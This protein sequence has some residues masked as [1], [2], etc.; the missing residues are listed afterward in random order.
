MLCALKYAILLSRI[1]QKSHFTFVT[2][3]L[4]PSIFMCLLHLPCL[5]HR[6]FFC[7]PTPLCAMHLCIQFCYLQRSMF[8]LA[9][10]YALLFPFLPPEM[11]MNLLPFFLNGD[12]SHLRRISS[13]H[14]H[15]LCCLFIAFSLPSTASE[16]LKKRHLLHFL[17]GAGCFDVLDLRQYAFLMDSPQIF[18]IKIHMS[19]SF[20]LRP[21]H[22]CLCTDHTWGDRRRPHLNGTQCSVCILVIEVHH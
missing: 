20:A 18:Q 7:C 13:V 6:Y 3:F 5:T 11:L 14:P 19:A 17:L 2:I 12:S 22:L 21:M 9:L 15:F 4:R 8:L 1:F 16:L 10:V